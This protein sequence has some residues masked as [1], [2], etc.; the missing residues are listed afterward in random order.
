MSDDSIALGNEEEMDVLSMLAEQGGAEED[1]ETEE[2]TEDLAELKER[3]SKRNKSLKKSKQANHRMQSEIDEL[4]KMVDE[5]RQSSAGKQNTQVDPAK[6]EQEAQA[7]AD[8]VLDNPAEAIK[9]ADY[10]QKQLEAGLEN[11]ATTFEQKI[12]Q[13]LDALDGRT[14]P[15]RIKYEAEIAMLKQNP[16]FADLDEATLIK[17][18]KNLRAVKPRSSVAGRRAPASEGGKKFALTPEQKRQMGYE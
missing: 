15:E 16:D 2:E 3:L 4:R 17:F 7:W 13:R 11:W 14:N 5:V 18:A 6:L 8:R 9:Y 1:E 12:L 10:K